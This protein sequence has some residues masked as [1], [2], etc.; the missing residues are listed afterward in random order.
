MLDAER[1]PQAR[2]ARRAIGSPTRGLQERQQLLDSI[3]SREGGGHQP[4]KQQMVLTQGL[5]DSILRHGASREPTAVRWPSIPVRSAAS[6]TMSISGTCPQRA[7]T[8]FL[9]RRRFRVSGC[10]SSGVSL[11]APLLSVGD[12]QPVQLGERVV[13]RGELGA[14]L[15]LQLCS[16]RRGVQR[17]VE[18]VVMLDPVGLEVV[19]EVFDPRPACQAA[20]A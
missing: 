15:L 7:C 17:L 13:Q 19:R 20:C 12:P 1:V 5:D 3:V 18:L 10:A 2:R 11:I 4:R 16:E 6:V 9:R 8:A 14:H